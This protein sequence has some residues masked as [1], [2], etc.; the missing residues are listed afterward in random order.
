M[1]SIMK[2]IPGFKGFS[3]DK[4]DTKLLNRQEAIINSM[5]KQERAFP[6]ILN[7]SRKKRIAK[8]CCLEVEDVNKLLKQ[9]LTMQKMMKKFAKFGNMPMSGIPNSIDKNFLK[10]ML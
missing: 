9:F 3:T 5:T 7:A 1:S 4:V 6:K 10:K 2:L 8:G